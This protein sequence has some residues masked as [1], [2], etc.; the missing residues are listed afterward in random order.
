M[1]NVFEVNYNKF[2]AALSLVLWLVLPPF[3]IGQSLSELTYIADDSPPL[4]YLDNGEL[5]GRAVDLLV[6]ATT[7][8][9][10]PIKR[11]DVKVIPWARAYREALAGP[12]R[13]LFSVYRMPVRRPPAS[14]MTL[15]STSAASPAE[16]M[17]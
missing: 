4:N 14:T 8:A 13:V 11:T 1:P 17:A 10:A 15:N 2:F 9:G 6:Q 5:K 3:V 16:P 7:L 12:N